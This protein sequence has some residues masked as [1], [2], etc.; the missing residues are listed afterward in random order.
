VSTDTPL[1]ERLRTLY[2][3]PVPADLDRR[4]EAAM[5]TVPVRRPGRS[6]RRLLAALAVAAIFAAAAAGPALEWFGGSDDPYERLWEVAV[7][8]DQSVAADGYR[9]TVQRAYADALGVRLAMIVEDLEGRWSSLAV[10]M[11]EATDSRGRVYEAWNW[12]GGRTPI[13]GSTAIAEWARFLLP[14][15]IEGDGAQTDDLKLR[16]SVTSLRVR[17]PEPLPIDPDPEQIFAS[18]GGEWS[19]EIDMPPIAEGHAVSPIASASAEGVTITLEELR[20]VPSGAAVRIAV[21]GLPDVPGSAYGWLPSSQI[22]HDG[23][24]FNDQP[25]EPGIMGSDGVVTIEARP[26]IEGAIPPTDPAGHWNIT[27]LSFYAFDATLEQ[28]RTVN[29]PWV[30][31]FDVPAAS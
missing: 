18:V 29:G 24:K 25:F 1:E 26:D 16:V 23:E 7:P 22:E 20:V 27:I 6:R 30:L 14:D 11:V 31:E 4:I 8:V 12:S 10:E 3:I 21:E 17:S 5:M 2:A 15:E 19:F 13:D 9:V 28:G